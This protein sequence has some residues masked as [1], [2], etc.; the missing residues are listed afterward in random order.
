MIN[1]YPIYSGCQKMFESVNLFSTTAYTGLMY[2]GI[3]LLGGK[4]A[5]PSTVS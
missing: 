2:C 1:F 4:K 3:Y 5:F